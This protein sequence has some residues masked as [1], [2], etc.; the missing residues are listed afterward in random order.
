[1]IV[2]NEE[3]MLERCLE[4]LV[5]IADEIIIVDTGSTDRTV[6]IAQKFVDKVHYFKWIDDFAAA[7]NYAQS[8]ATCEYV[9][10]WDADCTL[11]DG[12]M[13]KL[14]EIKSNNFD[15][16]D[17]YNLSYVEQFETLDNGKIVTLFQEEL[18]YFYR[19]RLFHWNGPI[20]EEL[21][22]HNPQ[23]KIKISSD[24]KILVLHHRKESG[25]LWRNK[26]NLEIL[27]SRINLKD[28]YYVRMLFFYARDLYFDLQY[29][30]SIKQFQSLLSQRITNEMRDYT[31]EKIIFALLYSNQKD[32]LSEFQNL[33]ETKSPRITLTKADL[34]CL[35]DPVAA[36]ELYTKYLQT[37]F[38]QKD[39][40]YEYDIERFQIHPYIQLAKLLIHTGETQKVKN[41]LQKAL[42]LKPSFE[43]KNRI[44]ELLK[45][46]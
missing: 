32:R 5:A 7:R 44:T 37:P 33:L 4:S 16:A 1:M 15:G 8:L 25:K 17:L 40:L 18:F 9:L 21:T 38:L 12:D 42:T 43:T 3:I 13:K 26:Q 30:E 46:T 10:R 20:H 35:S 34:M 14:F 23:T 45:Y 41:N 11:Q 28:K 6:E 2:K 27:K 19:R 36:L 31:I 39:S 22:L 29:N 24:T